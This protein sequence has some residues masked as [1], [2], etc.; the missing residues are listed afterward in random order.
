MTSTRARARCRSCSLAMLLA[1]VTGSVACSAGDDGPRLSPFQEGTT[2]TGRV[3]DNVTA[4]TVDAVC[5]LRIELADTTIE[6]VY[7]TGERPAPECEIPVVVSDA[8]FRAVAGD[9]VEIVVGP[10]GGEGLVMRT[11]E[12]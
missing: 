2:I 6:A 10:C 7:G 12:G 8:A 1:I 4:C 3:V 9:V 11:F 5:Y